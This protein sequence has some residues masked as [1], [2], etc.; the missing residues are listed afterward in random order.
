ML[1]QSAAVAHTDS[2]THWQQTQGTSAATAVY[3]SLSRAG[4]QTVATFHHRHSAGWWA[5]E[6]I[7]L[8]RSMLVQYMQVKSVD[9]KV[10]TVSGLKQDPMHRICLMCSILPTNVLPMYRHHYQLMKCIC[11]QCAYMAAVKEGRVYVV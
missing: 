5:T 4:Q 6:L 9:C 11:Y 10:S 2:V 7:T 1:G 8:Y 3:V